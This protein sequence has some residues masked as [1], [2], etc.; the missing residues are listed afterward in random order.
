MSEIWLPD[1]KLKQLGPTNWI[2]GYS[3]SAND[4]YWER[5]QADSKSDDDYGFQLKL[6]F[7]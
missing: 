5:L 4:E 3:Y 2:D 7:N 6:D 1:T